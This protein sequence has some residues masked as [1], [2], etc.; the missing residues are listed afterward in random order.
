[1]RARDGRRRCAPNSPRCRAP[2]A[3]SSAGM[4]NSASSSSSQAPVS[5]SRS[6]VREALVASVAW[7]APSVSRQS[8]KESTVPNASSPPARPRPRA[9]DVI[10]NPGD[11][12]GGEIGIEHQAGARADHRLAP[13]RLQPRAMFGGA[14]ILPDDGVVDRLA[15]GAAPHQRRLALVGQAECGELALAEAR[16]RR[17][18]RASSRASSPTDWPDRARSSRDG[19]RSGE[20]PSAPRRA[21]PRARRRGSRGSKSCPDRRR[22]WRRSR[23]SSP[24]KGRKRAYRLRRRC[25]MERRRGGHIG[26]SPCRVGAED[27]SSAPLTEP[28][29]RA[30]HPAL[31]IVVSER[32]S[33]LL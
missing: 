5:M 8:R 16:P 33:E 23:L 24:R 29:V 2:R 21:A 14:P 13:F 7:T 27:C 3:A 19:D 6:R 22:E 30:S 26:P 11:L 1:M 10:E 12:G 25:A 32:K 18:P 9:G 17:G 31:W 15:V 28:D 4:S 20:T